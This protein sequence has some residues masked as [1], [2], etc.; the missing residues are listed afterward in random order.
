MDWFVGIA[1]VNCRVG[2]VDVVL[3]DLVCSLSIGLVNIG[4]EI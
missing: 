2:C 4:D 3:S 1:V